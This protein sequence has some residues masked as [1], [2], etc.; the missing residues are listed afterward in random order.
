MTRANN[1][2]LQ[3]LS[4]NRSW[5][6]SRNQKM[7]THNDFDGIIT[8]LLLHKYLGWEL[9]GLYDLRN[10]HLKEG[11]HP[12]EDIVFVDLDV[13]QDNIK[14]I[15]HHVLAN[16]KEHSVNVNQLFGIGYDSFR[17][18]Y[19]LS[20][21]YFLLWL[22]SDMIEEAGL[23]DYQ[24]LLL[25]HCDTAWE[26]YIGRD[27]RYQQNTKQW[28]NRLD[29]ILGDSFEA[30]NLQDMVKQ[31]IHSHFPKCRLNSFQ[32]KFLYNTQSKQYY[33]EDISYHLTFNDFIHK[34][35]Q[36]FDCPTFQFPQN[37]RKIGN[38]KSHSLKIPKGAKQ[39]DIDEIVGELERNNQVF[40]Y[41]ISRKTLI[42]YTVWS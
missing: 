20:T 26:N 34:I 24:K 22:H 7:V 27:L 41:S 28:I 31:H 9:V 5:L 3:W 23:N 32:A 21:A 35:G 30:P 15:G 18:K 40:S 13:T 25:L 33:F 17:F 16:N 19:P 29:R 2:V 1:S 8:A 39:K 12:S 42:K 11:I 38:L 10:L 37:M 6:F 14:S 36:A 4:N